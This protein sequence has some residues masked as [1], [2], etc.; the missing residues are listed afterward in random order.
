[1]ASNQRVG[2]RRNNVSHVLNKQ[3]TLFTIKQ[4]VQRTSY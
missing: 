1:M 2:D 3:N 4:I